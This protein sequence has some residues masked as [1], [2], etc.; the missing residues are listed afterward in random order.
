MNDPLRMGSFEGLR[1]LSGT[2]QRFVQR[3]G[4]LCNAVGERGSLNQFKDERVDAMRFLD[5]ENRG[6]VG[7]VQRRKNLRFALEP[8][9]AV[10]I[11]REKVRENLESD[12]PMQSGIVAPIDLSHP[13]RANELADFIDAQPD[14]W[15]LR[16]ETR[17][18]L[19]GW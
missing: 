1:D 19:Y 11:E 18:G 2:R 4:T 14:T 16:H 6:D 3:E 10:R 17:P 9:E 15:R 13:T 12:V 7:M 5:A 8:S